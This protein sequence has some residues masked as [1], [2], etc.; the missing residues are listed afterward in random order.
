MRRSNRAAGRAAKASP[1][2]P[3]ASD[4]RSGSAPA[5]R[6]RAASRLPRRHHAGPLGHRVR[7]RPPR[8]AR[9]SPADQAKGGW[10]RRGTDELLEGA[11]GVAAAGGTAG[12]VLLIAT[13]NRLGVGLTQVATGP[14]VE[15]GHGG[16]EHALARFA[17][18][19]L[20]ALV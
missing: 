14:A 5:D 8:S 6:R 10:R 17:L 11:D 19:E 9:A 12:E 15:L 2:N 1:R 7:H 4:A 3:G 16:H 20:E 18:G 13:G